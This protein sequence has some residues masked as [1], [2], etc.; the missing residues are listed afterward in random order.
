M[1]ASKSW[2]TNLRVREKRTLIAFGALYLSLSLSI[3]GLFGVGYYFLAKENMLQKMRQELNPLAN[4]QV[5]ALQNLHISFDKNRIYPR[6]KIFNSGIYDA[7]GV[8]IFSLLDVRPE[9]SHI[10]Y[11]KSGMIHYIKEPQMHYLGTRYLVLEVEDDN[12]WQKEAWQRI[13]YG[14][15]FTLIILGVGGYFL[16][17]LFLRP[18]R[19]AVALLDRFIKDTT[20]ELNTPINAILSNIEMIEDAPLDEKLAK[21]FARIRIGAQT[22]ANLYQ[23]L[24][25]LTLGHKI[26][27]E[28]ES[29]ELLELCHE[30]VQYVEL[31]CESKNLNVKVWG[32]KSYL[33][34]DKKKI[35][36]IIDNLL[37]NAIKYNRVGG[38]INLHVVPGKLE[39]CDKGRGIDAKKLRTVFERYTRHETSV[40]GF[41]IGLSIVGVIAKEYGLI[42]DLKSSKEGTC[43]SVIWDSY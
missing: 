40:G 39:I 43:V 13:A 17:R 30:R 16:L 31:M 12:V 14:G 32:E 42:I 5:E 3:I 37:S 15:F 29:I 19:E 24:T 2:D 22:V 7:D 41:G 38:F 10:I 9:L 25:Y 35:T 6:N 1:L 8:E 36:K 18:M 33:Y 28:N 23:D 11:L 21:K 26:I 20:H 4:D 27:S 34:I